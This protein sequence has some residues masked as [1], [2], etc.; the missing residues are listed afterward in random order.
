MDFIVPQWPPTKA[1]K[2]RVVSKKVETKPPV[3]L[4]KQKVVKTQEKSSSVSNSI[5]ERKVPSRTDSKAPVSATTK[6]GA[7]TKS[8][9]ITRTNTA[10]QEPKNSKRNI[11]TR[12]QKNTVAESRTNEKPAEESEEVETNEKPP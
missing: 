5:T 6:T 11:V 3:P 4:A 9:K 12:P 7:A 2:P 8:T 1:L 10:K